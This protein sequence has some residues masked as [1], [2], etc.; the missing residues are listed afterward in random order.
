MRSFQVTV[1]CAVPAVMTRFWA[2][3]LGYDVETGR[4]S[5]PDQTTTQPH[6]ARTFAHHGAPAPEDAGVLTC[7]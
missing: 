3:A 1:D 2:S 6:Q 7:T 5:A 4:P